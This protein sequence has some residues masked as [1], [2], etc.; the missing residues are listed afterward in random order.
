[1]VLVVLPDFTLPA[2]KCVIQ[3]SQSVGY[4]QDVS[5]CV[6][7]FTTNLVGYQDIGA[8]LSKA[9][10]PHIIYQIIAVTERQCKATL[11]SQ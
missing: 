11:I 4:S 6:D 3:G 7:E 1:M 10:G 9:R 8:D 2:A 5:V